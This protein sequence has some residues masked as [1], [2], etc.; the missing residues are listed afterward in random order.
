[1]IHPPLERVGGNIARATHNPEWSRP[2]YGFLKSFP[3]QGL[4]FE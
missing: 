3:L 2:P 4:T 1:M